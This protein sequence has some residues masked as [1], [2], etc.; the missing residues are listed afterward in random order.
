MPFRWQKKSGGW[1]EEKL[2]RGWLKNI[3]EVTAVGGC[4]IIGCMNKSLCISLEI[5]EMYFFLLF[6]WLLLSP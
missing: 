1:C 6:I 4:E 5:K 3:K 2:A